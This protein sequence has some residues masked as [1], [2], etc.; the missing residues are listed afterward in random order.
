V[1]WRRWGVEPDQAWPGSKPTV[2]VG[3]RCGT[4]PIRSGRVEGG[5]GPGRRSIGCWRV[6]CLRENARAPSLEPGDGRAR[7][8]RQAFCRLRRNCAQSDPASTGD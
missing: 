8:V 7:A 3:S 1:A 6:A 2:S 5:G 4:R